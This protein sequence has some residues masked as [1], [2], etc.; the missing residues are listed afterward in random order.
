MQPHPV[1]RLFPRNWRERYGDEFVELFDADPRH[2]SKWVDAARTAAG[3]RLAGSAGAPVAGL[4][5]AAGCDVALGVGMDERVDPA[6]LAAHWWAAPL[7][8]ALAVG[9]VLVVAGGGALL[10]ERRRRRVAVV[11]SAVVAAGAVLG[12]AVVAAVSFDAAAL[13]AGAGLVVAA[14]GV[15]VA[16][17]T[18]PGRADVL[19]ALAIPLTLLLGWRWVGSPVGP[20]VL[21]VVL[22]TVLSSRVAEPATAA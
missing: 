7:L 22:G 17:R 18:R 10:A 14:L 19:V 16:L 13:G 21:V 4:A 20:V 15:R 3:L 9:A 12:S 6:L 2:V 11:A 8:V 1:L 5:L